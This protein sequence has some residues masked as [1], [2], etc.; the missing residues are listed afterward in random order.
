MQSDRSQAMLERLVEATNSH[1]ID[2]V[3]ACFAD[4]YVNETPAH[5]SRGFRGREQVRKNWTQIFEFVPDITARII[6]RCVDGETIWSEWEMTGSRRDGTP[7][8]MKGV[9]VFGVHDDVAHSARLYL[10]PVD[11]AVSTVDDA[12]R[13]QVVRQ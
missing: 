3:V 4:D 6:D 9:I 1:D 13:D 2:A 12:V 8:H 7:H 5:P 11:T 10:E